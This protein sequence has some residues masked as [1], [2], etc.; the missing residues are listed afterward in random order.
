MAGQIE[1][2]V[3]MKEESHPAG[4]RYLGTQ[5]GPRGS[6]E[7]AGP[8]RL[9]ELGPLRPVSRQ[10][11]DRT[12]DPDSKPPTGHQRASGKRNPRSSIQ[13]RTD[14]RGVLEPPLDSNGSA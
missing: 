8:F 6:K 13:G 14:V 10:Q 7:R 4:Q 3:R 1:K 5:P 11:E 2:A 12:A 9:T